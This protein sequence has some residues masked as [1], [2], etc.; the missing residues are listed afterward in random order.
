VAKRTLSDAD[1]SARSLSDLRDLYTSS[2]NDTSNHVGR[3]ADVL[4]L[5]LLSILSSYQ[6]R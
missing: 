3:N 1:A 6:A 5:Q 2:A 4:R